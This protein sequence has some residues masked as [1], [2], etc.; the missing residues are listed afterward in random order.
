MVR[1][2]NVRFPDNVDA[3][4][5][6]VGKRV[7]DGDIRQMALSG[8]LWEN[9][10]AAFDGPI[11]WLLEGPR[12]ILYNSLSDFTLFCLLTRDDCLMTAYSAKFRQI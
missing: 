3:L 11:V 4:P 2:E 5:P 8:S 7:N 10:V 12:P 1:K 6:S 9:M